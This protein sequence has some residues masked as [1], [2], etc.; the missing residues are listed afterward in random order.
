[1]RTIVRGTVFSL[2]CARPRRSEG[3][4]PAWHPHARISPSRSR[5][6]CSKVS[7]GEARRSARRA[8]L[9]AVGSN[10][11]PTSISFLKMEQRFLSCVG[12]PSHWCTK[13]AISPYCR[14]R[15]PRL[16]PGRRLRN[17]GHE[18]T[19]KRVWTRGRWPP[20]AT[21][22]T[23][24]C[25]RAPFAR[26]SRRQNIGKPDFRR[27][28]ISLLNSSLIFAVSRTMRGHPLPQPRGKM[29]WQRT[30]SWTR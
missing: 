24:R 17:I 7:D 29:R 12:K 28:L 21:Q 13:E 8:P 26:V 22:D 6:L 10:T 25:V 30:P 20:S 1:M 16:K 15:P 18:W 23:P 2:A 14:V 27:A 4:P 11:A 19:G 9:S 5:D 3:A